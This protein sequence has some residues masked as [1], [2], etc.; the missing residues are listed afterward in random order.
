VRTTKLSWRRIGGTRRIVTELRRQRRTRAFS[1]GAHTELKPRIGW[2]RSFAKRDKQKLVVK[3][4]IRW[5]LWKASLAR[6]LPR[7]KESITPLGPCRSAK[8]AS[9]AMCFVAP[10]LPAFQKSAGKVSSQRE[11]APASS[12]SSA[13]E[14]RSFH[15]PKRATAVTVPFPVPS[16]ACRF[17]AD[18]GIPCI[19]LTKLP[20]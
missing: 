13:G 14:W 19:L 11:E 9:G 7:R 10:T 12:L 8:S 18:P 16:R 1:Q 5:P 20:V 2:H 6:T 4:S 15:R 3:G 17:C